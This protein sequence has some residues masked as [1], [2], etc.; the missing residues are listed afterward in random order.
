VAIAQIYPSLL[1]ADF[2][3][4]DE[5]AW[6]V[7]GHADW[8]HVDVMDYHFVPNLAFAPDTVEALR[9]VTETPLDCHLMISDP[10]RWAP[11]YA[12]RGAANVTI[13]AEA[14]SNLP[15]TASAIRA[16]GARV[17]LAVKPATPVEH[18]ADD[19]HRFDLLLLMTIEPGF[20]GQKFMDEV[21]PKIAAA[22]QLLDDRGL[23]LWLQID[24]G[25]N[26]ETI[27][28]A[29]EA[30]VDVFVAGTAVFEA[31]DPAAAVEAL[32]AQALRA[33]PRLVAP[34]R[35]PPSAR[36]GQLPASTE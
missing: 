21:L 34:E 11:G 12:E 35:R 33:A 32:R 13:H 24:G 30:G 9:K 28:R 17:G 29:A 16:A 26:A 23:G 25:V 31:A 27:E 7:E 1:G 2:G 6:A 14:V 20:G 18:Y 36:S 8:L 3:R 22:R 19:L 15:R 4:V 5:A 10:D